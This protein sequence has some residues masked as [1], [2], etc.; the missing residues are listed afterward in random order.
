[1]STLRINE[2][3]DVLLSKLREAY[4]E[5]YLNGATVSAVIKTEAG[6]VLV[7][8]FAMTYQAGTDGEYLGVINKGDAA[9]FVSGTAYYVEV[10][11]TSSEYDGFRR[12]RVTAQ[13]HGATP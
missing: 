9:N 8:S 4:S 12:F 10:T 11:I 7:P 3:N 13:H 6:V 2:D 1:M 5:S